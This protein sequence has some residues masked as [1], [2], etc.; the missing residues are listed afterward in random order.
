MRIRPVLLLC[1]LVCLA[2]CSGEK[3]EATKPPRLV[4]A[5]TQ[6]ATLRE[7]VE[8]RSFPAQ[9][10]S[11]RSVT[12]ASK[13]SGTVEAVEAQEGDMVRA[14]ALIMRLDD[15]DLTSQKQGLIAS[16]EQA[17]QEKQA[18]AA[19]A[20]LAKITMG[21][22][23][24]L[25]AG[26][27]VSQEDFD[28]AKAEYDALSRQVE[29][30]AA[31]EATS[32]AKMG[33]LTALRSYTRITAP[34]DGILA[35]R[36]VDQ[37]AFVTAGAPLALVDAST[38]NYDL[39][40][41]VDESLMAGLRQDQIILAVI[42]SL[43]HDPFAVTVRAVVGRVDPASRTFK[44]KCALPHPVP[45]SETP[46]RAGMFGR[47]FVPARQTKKLLVPEACLAKRGDLPTV[48]VADTDG[49]LHFRVVKTGASFLAVDFHGRTYLTDS[50]AFGE[51]G[52]ERFVEVISGLS[53][54]E[55]I[56]CDP[57]AT[58]REG[59]RLAGAGK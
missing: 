24:K 35:K 55:R 26:R 31:Q 5:A 32:V 12:L 30:A 45:G 6:P 39:T 21:R 22:M 52:R 13:V 15:K 49:V 58:L 28:K 2:G 56:A 10:E 9:V 40:A 41:Q 11:A 46:P 3:P 42:P 19:K 27:A 37:G 8:C 59:D 4:T 25:L 44:L 17:V 29:A 43:S 36:Y 54:G 51:T 38:G 14:G 16:R 1:V 7:V 47:V 50:E 34:F 23:G 57:G 20:A 48:T 53:G 18:L 33:E